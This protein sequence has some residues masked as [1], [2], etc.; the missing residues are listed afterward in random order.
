MKEERLEAKILAAVEAC[1]GKVVAWGEFGLDFSSNIWGE[2]PEYKLTQLQ[3]FERQ[4]DLALERRLPLT[5]HIRAAAD[6]ALRVLVA[7]VPKDWKAH[8]HAFHGPTAFVEQIMAHFPNF[9]FGL[10]GTV[11]M[12]GLGDGARMAKVVPLE[13]MVLETDGPYLLVKGTPFNHCGQIPLIAKAVAEIRGCDEAEVL[14]RSRV[15][16]RFIYGI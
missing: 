5:L 1:P 13:K 10:S 3:V 14:S 2:D 4:I 15:N 12:G 9:Y 16:S 11:T 6:D 7:R 8:V